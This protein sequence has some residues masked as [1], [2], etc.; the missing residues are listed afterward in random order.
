MFYAPHTLMLRSTTIERDEDGFPVGAEQE[1]WEQRAQCRCDDDGTTEIVDER[2]RVL[3]AS[4]HIVADKCNVERG[5]HVRV[6]ERNAEG[7]VIRK[8]ETNYFEYIEL[9]I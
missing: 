5:D 1:V 3:R 6:P 2:G 8:C 4:Y 9:W 7:R